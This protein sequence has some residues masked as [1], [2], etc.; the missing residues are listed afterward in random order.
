[1]YTKNAAFFWNEHL[2]NPAKNEQKNDFIQIFLSE[3]LV[4]CKWKSDSL[5]KNERF[6]RVAL[7]SWATWAFCSQLLIFGEWPE[8]IAHGCSF[9]VSN[10]CNSLTVALL[11]WV[12]WANCSQ[13]LFKMSDFEQKSKFPT[14]VVP[15]GEKWRNK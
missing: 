4:L 13:L 5:R 11:S 2:P 1:M 10:L 14:L 6:A 12:I 3:S 7:L 9:L 15:L 8:W